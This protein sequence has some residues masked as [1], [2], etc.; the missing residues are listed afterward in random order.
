MVSFPLRVSHLCQ[1]AK[2]I[3]DSGTVG[4]IEHLHAVN[5]V[6]YG[7]VYFDAWHRDYSVTQGLFL[8]KATHDFD[9]LSFL[10]G[11][12]IIRVAAMSTC[13]RV[14]R[15]AKNRGLN[16][17]PD[18]IY[19]DNIGTPES[20]MNEDSSS[21]LIEFA[22]GA[23]GVYTQVFYS[24]RMPRRGATISGFRG[25]V[26]FDW[27]ENKI[28]SIHHR[29]PITDVTTVGESE[30]HFGGDLELAS[31]FIDMIRHGAP[32]AAPIETG[33]ASVYA[34]LAAKESAETGQFIN[35]T[36]TGINSCA[37]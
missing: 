20:G 6:T 3:L 16:P 12:P 30:D 8:Q 25:M 11:A 23:K 15:D 19:L 1:R 22:N 18:A 37:S 26:E 34:C 13:G 5:Y 32:S 4:P 17:S 35:V 10:A 36:Q 9:Y 2:H 24:K 14:Y 7:N 27:Y 29:E 28:T 31:N 33:L 21:A